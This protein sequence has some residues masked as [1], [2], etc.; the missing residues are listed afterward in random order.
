M[1]K[2]TVPETNTLIYLLGDHIGSSSVTTDASGVKT[3]SAL[4]KAFGETRYCEAP[5]KG[6]LGNLGTDYKFTGQREEAALGIYFFNA[7]WFDPSLGRFI[8]PDTIVPTGTQGTQ[9]WDR[10]AYVNNNPVKYND[11]TGHLVCQEGQMASG[12]K[13]V[14]VGDGGDYGYG[15]GGGGDT[16]SNNHHSCLDDLGDCYMQGW[17]N[18]NSATETITDPN[19]PAVAEVYA[20]VYIVGWGGFHLALVAGLA[21]LGCAAATPGCITAAGGGAASL[22][23]GLFY[24]AVYSCL[25]MS[26]CARLIGAGSGVTVLGKIPDSGTP[27]YV[28]A[29]QQVINGKYLYDPGWNAPMQRAFEV[30][31]ISSGRPVLFTNNPVLHNPSILFNEFTALAKAGWNNIFNLNIYMTPP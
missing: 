10:Y 14:N 30:D 5:C 9:A 13:C 6:T 4:Y 8:S 26:L 29:G 23:R 19:T 11:P 16:N 22:G 1:K 20:W 24:G 2:N 18:F 27:D 21:G 25:T 3:A 15:G 31:M 12:G 28:K 7:R 17:T